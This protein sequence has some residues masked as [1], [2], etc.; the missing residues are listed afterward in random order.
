MIINNSFFLLLLFLI[1]PS[2]NFAFNPQDDD[3]AILTL[4]RG[5][6]CVP[7]VQKSK[8][9]KPNIHIYV[10]HIL[11][12]DQTLTDTLRFPVFIFRALDI[13]QFDNMPDQNKFYEL[14]SKNKN[15]LYKDL[16]IDSDKAEFVIGDK[17][18][19][20]RYWNGFITLDHGIKQESQNVDV[21][22][23]APETGIYCVY[24]APPIIPELKSITVPVNFVNGYG[25]LSFLNYEHYKTLRWLILISI[26]LFVAMFKHILK[27]VDDQDF[28]NLNQISII[29]KGII[30]YVIPPLFAV[31]VFEYLIL[32][33]RNRYI[34]FHTQLASTFTSLFLIKLPLF[35][36]ASF[37][38]YTK[39]IVLLFAM[40][41]GVIYYHSG[42]S[43]RYRKFPERRF[44]I[45][46][47][48]LITNLILV[49]AFALFYTE[50][51]DKHPYPFII[52][53]TSDII[54][55]ITKKEPSSTSP[56]YSTTVGKSAFLVLVLFLIQILSLVWMV[57]SMVYY[58]VTKRT[59]AQ[60][61]PVPSSA[62]NST[63]KV[64]RA[65][66]L[67]MW[68]IFGLP[69]LVGALFIFGSV[70]KLS[71]NLD[72]DALSPDSP[73]P[74]NGPELFSWMFKI[75][76]A[77]EFKGNFFLFQIWG[78]YLSVI[79][80][81]GLMF[82]IW[83]KENNGLVVDSGADDPIEYADVSEFEINDDD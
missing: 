16:H 6:V 27:F 57:L 35:I 1:F 47:L 48:L 5:V 68:V 7:I 38:V 3:P 43:S 28:K 14:Y 25:N 42:N 74:A 46:L 83:V 10:D 29:S 40:G 8:S 22:F 80:F 18:D 21:Q 65:F 32:F 11:T 33:I 64:I 2:F 66:R 34:S 13:D 70:W 69:V 73:P 71:Q 67:S 36:T 24:I 31:S 41:Y 53:M 50:T 82:M 60:F 39:F 37:F 19:K 59:I 54:F 23:N 79:L 44:T 51:L 75:W 61:P 55:N 12:T 58:F 20:S 72:L 56:A 30:I 76:E 26:I 4:E 9:S 52:Q 49:A 17:V 63:D 78:D 81:I 62:P 15:Q 77:A 45:A